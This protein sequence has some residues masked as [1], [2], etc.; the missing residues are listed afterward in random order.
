[1]NRF[2]HLFA[3]GLLAWTELPGQAGAAD[4]DDMAPAFDLPQHGGS[5][6]GQLADLKGKIVILDFFAYWCVPCVRASTEMETGL[7]QY[8][9]QR[10]GNSHG[11]QI[12]LLAINVEA[13]QPEKT[14]AFIRLT[15]LKQVLDDMQG[16][17][18]QKYGGS[19]MP[20]LVIIDATGGKT[21]NAPARVVYREAGFEG[22]AKLRQVIET[23][24]ETP[25]LPT[26]TETAPSHGAETLA[27]VAV[28]DTKTP[29]TPPQST[30]TNGASAVTI[31]ASSI[32]ESATKQLPDRVIPISTNAPAAITRGGGEV[33]HNTSLDFATMWASDILLTDELLEYRQT[34]PASEMSLTLSQGHIA[35]RYVPDTP[36]EQAND[37]ESDSFGLQARSRFRVNDQLNG[38]LSG[39]AYYGYQDYRS[40]WL[41]EHYRQLFS[42][43]PGY[44]TAYPWGCNAAGGMRWEYLPAAGF[45]EGDLEYQHDVI[46][47]GYDVSLATFP[48][49]L[50][51]FRDDFDTISGSLSLENVLTRRL[52]ALQEL[53][54]TDTTECQLRFSLQSSFNYAVAEHWVARSVFAGTEESPQFKAVSASITVERD[55][56][57]TWFLSLMARY[58]QDNGEVNA[59]LVENTAAPPLESFQCGMGLR[60]QGRKTSIKLFAGP[61]FARYQQTGPAFDTFPHLY[62]NRDWFAV[63]FAFAHEF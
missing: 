43:R 15:G 62:Q 50:E 47:P 44:E 12:E 42:T 61:Y 53:W 2:L 57:E 5:Q 18:F 1:M 11:I 45:V 3:I 9:E 34:R 7:R 37:V 51:R 6:R 30:V 35:L 28:P 46:S 17:V 13:S 36:I 4:F 8:Y 25:V 38:S 27:S 59:V 20:F 60:W 40:L 31:K 55:W 26:T 63:Q 48:L 54:I 39:G 14:E 21:G 52:R 24:G 22:V 29:Q 33:V 16:E 49:K 58:Y 32:L 23:I 56:E 10:Q 19:G 41:N